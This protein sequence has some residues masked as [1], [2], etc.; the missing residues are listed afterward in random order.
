MAIVLRC[1]LQSCVVSFSMRLLIPYILLAGAI[2]E[3]GVAISVRLPFPYCVLPWADE[4]CWVRMGRGAHC[5][6]RIAARRPSQSGAGV[7][8]ERLSASPVS[9]CIFLRFLQCAA[10]VVA[11]RCICHRST[12]RQASHRC[13]LVCCAGLLPG[14]CCLPWGRFACWLSWGYLLSWGR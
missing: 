3:N 13:A 4:A 2:D 1:L 14:V 5:V 11:A 6:R 7:W 8:W 9:C 12:L 10:S